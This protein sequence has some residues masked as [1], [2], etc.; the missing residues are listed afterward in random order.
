M[1]TTIYIYIYIY[2]YGFYITDAVLYNAH[3]APQPPSYYASSQGP[4]P[5][6]YHGPPQGPSQG[7]SRPSADTQFTGNRNTLLPPIQGPS[8]MNNPGMIEQPPSYEQVS[9]YQDMP[10]KK[11]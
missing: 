4:A 10:K 9:S 2:I 11:W 8:A 6:P 7:P 5:G 3:G 1:K